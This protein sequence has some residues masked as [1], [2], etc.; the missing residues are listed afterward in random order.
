MSFKI[1]A[2]EVGLEQNMFA[3]L[4]PCVIDDLALCLEIAQELDRIQTR[5]GI[6]I[7][8]KGSFDKANRTDV[9][10]YRGMGLYEGLNVLRDIRERTGL[11]VMTDIHVPKQAEIATRFVSALQIP[12]FLCRQTDLL[13]KA[14]MTGLPINVKKGQFQAPWDMEAVVHKIKDVND[15]ARNE[16]TKQ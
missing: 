11:P 15:D 2:V 9:R 12:A 5:T 8:F 3:I 13:L 4:G 14:A 7:I 6:G 16:S 1:G 10:S